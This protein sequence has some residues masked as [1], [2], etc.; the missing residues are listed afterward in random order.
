MSRDSTSDASLLS[1]KNCGESSV[2]C[3]KPWVSHRPWRSP[4]GRIENPSPPGGFLRAA[5]AVQRDGGWRCA[6]GAVAL[7]GGGCRP[8]HNCPLRR[9]ARRR[10]RSQVGQRHCQRTGSDPRTSR[11]RESP[12]PYVKPS[13]TCRKREG[14]GR[15]FAPAISAPF[16]KDRVSPGIECSRQLNRHKHTLR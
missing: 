4:Q 16:D 8:K 5:E 2:A 3:V 14:E 6:P 15:F 9:T 12:T 10:L 13:V 11:P 1:L 7:G